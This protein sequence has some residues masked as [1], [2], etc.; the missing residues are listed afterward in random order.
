MRTGNSIASALLLAGIS[1]GPGIA[2]AQEDS[3]QPQSLDFGVTAGA[4]WSDNISM[5]SQNE[6]SGTIAEVGLDL[7]YNQ[8]SRRLQTDIEIN[9]AYQR[10]VDDEFDDDFIGGVDGT[11][12]VGVV[13][14]HF[15]W[16]FQDNFGQA[17][18]DP[19]AASTPDNSED[20]NYFTT[21][22]DVTLRFSNRTS[23]RIGGRY[24]LTDY[25]TAELDGDR[26][27]AELALIRQVSGAS[28]L[29]LNVRGE[30]L[31]FDDTLTGG[32]YDNY[33]RYEG[34]VRY[35]L[36]NSRTDLGVDVGY[37]SIDD[38][39]DS[40]AGSLLRLV[41]DRQISPSSSIQIRAGSEFSDAGNVFRSMQ[42]VSGVSTDPEKVIETADAL[43]R[44][45]GLLG[46]RFSRNRTWFGFDAEYSDESY[47]ND[48]TLD[49]SLV[50]YGAYIGRQ[51]TPN[52]RVEFD[53]RMSNEDFDRSDVE[54]DEF[55]TLAALHW[56]LGR[57]LSCRLQYEY[58]DRDGSSVEVQ[59]YQESRASLFLTWFPLGRK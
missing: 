25:E 5:Q 2:V 21:G 50:R 8:R 48:V 45:F 36:S 22:P 40:S 17:R 16:F 55:Q 18:V 1:F 46:W 27:S 37:N 29:S 9:T 41:L 28:A 20:V 4:I 24:S 53:A 33:D 54:V 51:L 38:G 31:N 7:R 42:E 52:V 6:E 30:R 14:D 49:R 23:M 3:V 43:E 47:E 58:R 13:P 10:Y 15:E 12:I 26:Y 44:R 32:G 56:A 59:Q 39:T 34:F 11:L 19:L 35:E 57:T